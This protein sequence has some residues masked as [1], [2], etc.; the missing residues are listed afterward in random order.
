MAVK[1]KPHQASSVAL[2]TLL[3]LPLTLDAPLDA[4]RDARCGY[5]LNKMKSAILK[6]EPLLNWANDYVAN[7]LIE[8]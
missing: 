4:Q 3:P 7:Y 1:A 8:M 2:V 5:T 6:V